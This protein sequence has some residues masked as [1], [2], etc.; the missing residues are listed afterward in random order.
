MRDQRDETIEA[1]ERYGKQGMIISVCYGNCGQSGNLY[2]VTVMDLTTGEEFDKPFGASSFGDI[3]MILDIEV[4][5]LL[6]K[7]RA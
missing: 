3:A 7:R 2:S 6:A 5:K 1:I 4:P